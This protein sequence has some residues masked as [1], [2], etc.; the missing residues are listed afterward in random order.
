MTNWLQTRLEPPFTSL[1]QNNLSHL[2]YLARIIQKIK[3][4][5]AFPGPSI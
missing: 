4:I 2:H 3:Q 1:L 5:Q